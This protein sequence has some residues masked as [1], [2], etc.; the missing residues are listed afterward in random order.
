MV[1][2]GS[3]QSDVGT[4]FHEPTPEACLGSPDPVGMKVYCPLLDN[5][6]LKDLSEGNW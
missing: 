2:V 6:M 5:Q 4:V 1:T 3:S